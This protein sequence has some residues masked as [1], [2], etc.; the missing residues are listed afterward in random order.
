MK[1][2][3]PYN[4]IP[5]LAVILIALLMG[6]CNLKLSS[7]EDKEKELKENP[8]RKKLESLQTEI[9]QIA[10]AEG[11]ESNIRTLVSVFK[12]MD[13]SCEAEDELFGYALKNGRKNLP[14]LVAVGY[15]LYRDRIM[16]AAEERQ[17]WT[18]EIWKDELR[19]KMMFEAERMRNSYWRGKVNHE[20]YRDYI[21]PM[22]D[23]AVW[24]LQTLWGRR[25]AAEF[26]NMNPS[27]ILVE[28]LE[29]LT[30]STSTMLIYYSLFAGH[31][32]LGNY[33]NFEM[34]RL[35]QNALLKD[36][37]ERCNSLEL[38]AKSGLRVIDLRAPLSIQAGVTLSM[39]EHL[40]IPSMS[41][42]FVRDTVTGDALEGLLIEAPKPPD[43]PYYV[44]PQGY[45]YIL[46]PMTS[47]SEETVF[48]KALLKN[49]RRENLT[50]RERILQ[51]LGKIEI[52]PFVEVSAELRSPR[53]YRLVGYIATN[54]LEETEQLCDVA[55]TR[56]PGV[57]IRNNDGGTG[58]AKQR[59][60][61]AK[62]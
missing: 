16:Q 40:N 44:W 49:D 26:P 10:S 38:L 34:M 6:G 23:F 42:A 24:N 5:L 43:S 60:S 9:K 35:R 31:E 11:L 4:I 32:I 57:Q 41:P 39:A 17:P 21:Q 25:N 62:L 37:D 19:K 33:R 52:E 58:H 29:Y 8:C 2:T 61:K 56:L 22:T 1:K 12:S 30:H 45:S 55:L 36:S 13:A 18:S 54:L 27:E 47:I 28:D 51:L 20:E 7:L 48:I 59:S 15:A 46:K 53:H 3:I 50:E 14:F